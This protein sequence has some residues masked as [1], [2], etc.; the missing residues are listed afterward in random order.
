MNKLIS[1]LGRISNLF[2]RTSLDREIESELQ[3]HIEMRTEDN[4][5]DGMSPERAR[6]DALARFGNPTV[7]KEDV[8]FA[9]AAV[10]LGSVWDDTRYAFR[11]LRKSPGF[12]ATTILTLAIGIGANL[13]IFQLLYGVLFAHLPVKQPAELYSLHAVQSPFDGEW[14]FSFPAYRRL[15]QATLAN[16]P[17]F[18]RSGFGIGVLQEAA[19]ATSRVEFQLVS[20]NFFSVLGLS[21]SA[22]RFFLDGDDRREQSEWPVILGYGYFKQHF[23]ENQQVLGKRSTFNGVPIVIVGVAPKGFSGVVRGQAPDLWLPLAAQATNRF[24]TWFDSLGP[25]YDVNLDRSYL[26]QA[27][28]FWL[29]V[30]SRTPDGVKPV[31]PAHWTS[32][33]APDVSLLAA[34][35]KD[36]RDRT[37]I[38]NS[39]VTLIS[40]ENGEGSLAKRYSRPLIILMAMAVVI[41]LVGCLNLANLQMARLQQREIEIATRIALGASRTR[42]L[43]QVAIETVVLA[44]MGGVLAFATGRAASS[45]L[46]HWA[47]GR[48]QAIPIDPQIGAAATLLG[49]ALL[50]GALAGFGLLPAWQMTRKSFS[51]ASKAR[52]GQLSGQ[53]KAARRWSNLLLASQVSFS[54][55]LLS[56]AVLFAQTLRNLSRVDAGMDRDHVLTVHLDM[57]NTGF[58]EHQ[59]NLPSFYDTVIQHLQALPMVRD[60]A[61]HMCTIPHC[62]WNTAVHVFGRP[63]IA[64]AQLH[65]EEDRVG[66][67]YFRTLGIP[68]LQG[69][70][71]G[72]EDNE[73]SQQV[74]ILSRSYARKLFGDESPLGHWVGYSAPPGDHQF[75]VVGEV[76]DA[77]VDG[78][79][80]EA[81]PV[82]YFPIDQ[83]P[84]PISSVEVRVR[85][86]L[87]RL[88]AEIRESLYK[89]APALPV[90]EI[91]SLDLEFDDSLSTETLLARL[92]SIFGALTLALAALGFYG[93]FSFRVARR[94]PEIGI[95]MALGA[96]RSQVRALFL[97]QTLKIIVA[98][99]IPGAVLAVGTSY[100]A[101]KMLYGTGPMD[102]WAMSFAVIILASVGLLATL[103]PAHQAASIDPMGA[104]RSE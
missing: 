58:A 70:D 78:L 99:L 97:G 75:L 69:R 40:A 55:L 84:G 86:P 52:V 7:T 95:R 12:A 61:V 48:G 102:I 5:A 21:P 24:G 100:F 37:R 34:A 53:S 38:R 41:L 36:P 27:S 94:T 47:S 98:G 33:L 8:V 92:T 13:A 49:T 59:N 103:V 25:G 83:R 66:V 3:S 6:R 71:F 4:L 85:G 2:S 44:G 23:A 73:R 32:A 28:I 1:I 51:T 74:A 67:G 68:I 65:G 17:V 101:R 90:T 9:D 14:F 77:R 39:Q 15:R 42:V 89:L 64:E 87:S 80:S 22:G 10:V 54:L 11:Q 76:A 79:R 104:L 18:A 46:L 26:N 72:K 16:A 62:G 96:T 91:V 93:L 43:R 30:L 56:A 20:D 50:L 82:A 19:G 63:E 88:P 81:P 29:W 60:V 57:R 45:L 35:S 31:A